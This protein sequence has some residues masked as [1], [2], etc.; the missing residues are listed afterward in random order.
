MIT[1]TCID[2][3]LV[4]QLLYPNLFL[5][6]LFQK[7]CDPMDARAGDDMDDEDSDGGE[8]MQEVDDDEAKKLTNELRESCFTGFQSFV[9]SRP[10]EIQTHLPQIVNASLAYM[11]YD[12][13]Y[14][15]GDEGLEPLEMDDETAKD[16]EEEE[17]EEDYEEEDED[18]YSDDDDDSWKVRRSAIRTLAAV[19]KASDK[20]LSSLWN[21]PYSSATNKKWKSTVAEALVNRFKERDE[22]CRVDIIDC[23]CCLLKSTIGA[24][25]N[26]DIR[27]TASEAMDV[28]GGAQVITNFRSLYAKAIVSGCEKQLHEKK[29]G[30]HTK[31]ASLSLLATLC[32]APG[33][34]GDVSKINAIFHQM[35]SIFEAGSDSGNTHGSNKQLKLDALCLVYTIITCGQHNPADVKEGILR[36]LLKELC[37]AVQENWYKI[38]SET[39]KVL[40]VIPTILADANSDEQELKGAATD[41]YDAIEPRLAANDF[42]QEIKESALEAAAALVNTLHQHLSQEQMQKLFSLILFRLKNETTRIAAMKTIVSIADETRHPVVGKV[43]MDS[44]LTEY[45]T[46][47]VYLLRQ[48]SRNVKQHAIMCLNTLIKSYGTGIVETA[49]SDLMGLVLRD[50]STNISENSDIYI[51]DLSLQASLTVLDQCSSCTAPVQ[52]YLLPAVLQLCTSSSLQDKALDSLIAVLQQFIACRITCFND[53]MTSLHSTLPKLP[54]IGDEKK[55]STKKV[56]GTIAKCMAAITSS[57][58][59]SERNKVVLDLMPLLQSNFTADNTYNIM[60]ALRMLG[61]LGCVIDLNSIENV[62]EKLLSIYIS[63]F[64]SPVEDIKNAA[65]YGLGRGSVGSIALFLPKIF[66]ALETSGDKEKYLLLSAIREFIHCHRLGFGS[67]I[68][69]VLEQILT[70]L[71]VFFSSENE[72]IRTKTA[73]CMGSLLCLQP[74]VILRDLQNLLQH[75][76]GDALMCWTIATSVKLA[77]SGGCDEQKLSPFMP[78]FLT[79]FNA[80]DLDVKNA[81]L[82]M[83]YA[84]FHHNPQLVLPFMEEQIEP[85]LLEVCYYLFV[86]MTTIHFFFF[87]DYIR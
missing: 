74:D 26:G 85:S 1:L 15:Y 31:S 76:R 64:E 37:K 70:R 30:I 67:D 21:V 12:P 9:L 84:S 80:E 25:K 20:N 13:N 18:D 66:S 61:D 4:E 24:A 79:L 57:A 46:E 44:Y 82:L 19:V 48:N 45:M 35:K 42:D 6:F 78:T 77:I 49:N 47:L 69:P 14:S 73:D 38:I 54:Q 22:N 11:R 68:S 59:E 2:F 60:L 41:L 39:L 5:F 17:E 62:G 83:V 16:E 86:V 75:N 51:I 28:E 27:F 29:A 36:V 50:L 32:L 43:D 10:V 72:G 34:I 53:L 56:I 58:N 71:K 55:T 65:A 3:K 23:L 7:F 33:G 81:V 8:E 87:N 52:Q 40:A 63:S